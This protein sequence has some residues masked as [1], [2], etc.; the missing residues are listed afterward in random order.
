[1]IHD[2]FGKF[3]RP[4]LSQHFSSVIYINSMN[5]EGAKALIERERPDIVIDQRVARRIH[6]SV[7]PD[8]ELEQHLVAEKFETMA[9][10]LITVDQSNWEDYFYQSKKTDI[11]KTV[12]GLNLFF[13]GRDAAV[14]LL[15]DR[16]DLLASPLVVKIALSS[17]HSSRMRFCSDL[18][19][20]AGELLRKQC[21]ERDLDEGANLIF[22]RLFNPQPPVILELTPED[23]GSFTLHS[24]H[25]KQELSPEQTTAQ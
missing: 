3:L 15:F 25:V 2:S 14:H 23:A 5:F 9:P 1:V 20:N 17:E 13:S 4:Y 24:L 8:P 12:D 7:L 6:R 10:L 19:G 18:K 11:R 16:F 22:F 21:E